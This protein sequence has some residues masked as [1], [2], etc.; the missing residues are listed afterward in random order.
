MDIRQAVEAGRFH[1]QWL[2]DQTDFELDL[3]GEETISKLKD[4]GH[5]IKARGSLGRV[6]ALTIWSDG[7][8]HSGA[9]PRGNNSAC[10]Y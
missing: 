1:N 10:G 4:M 9:D 2:P 6:N 7:L 8:I 3:F 5:T